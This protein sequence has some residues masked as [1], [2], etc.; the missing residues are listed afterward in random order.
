MDSTDLHGGGLPA[1]D[2]EG[3]AADLRRLILKKRNTQGAVWTL[4]SAPHNAQ[5]TLLSPLLFAP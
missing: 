3:V 5:Q 4:C 1:N 2:A